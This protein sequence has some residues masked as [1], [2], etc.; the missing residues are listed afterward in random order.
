MGTSHKSSDP[1]DYVSI[2]RRGTAI[3]LPRRFCQ[4]NNISDEMRALLS[5]PAWLLPPVASARPSDV[6]VGGE[7]ASNEAGWT[8]PR[9][10]ARGDMAN[11][12][13]VDRELWCSRRRLPAHRLAKEGL[14]R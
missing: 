8:G 9:S 10:A 6:G 5:C 13:R 4:L 2:I 11:R 12:P 3:R 14:T 1:R 7:H